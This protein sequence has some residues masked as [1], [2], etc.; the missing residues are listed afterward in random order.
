MMAL[1]DIARP[2][3]LKSGGQF[4]DLWEPFVD[5]ENKFSAYGPDLSGQTTKLRANDGVHFT[6]A[7]A[8]KAAHFVELELRRLMENKP[9]STVIA[10][11]A[12]TSPVE[13]LPLELQP[14]GV[15]RAI[16]RM[17]QGLPE[18]VGIPNLPMKPAAGPILTLNKPPV[19]PGATL[20][21]MRDPA[22]PSDAQIV[23]ERVYGEGRIG[24][25][26]PGRVDDFRWSR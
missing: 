23:I 20:A 18:P 14:G 21:G 17:V 9:A 25:S 6:K 12:E 24:D 4:V 10:I 11:P 5:A 1:N 13:K 2:Q 19:S 16:D 22:P 8:R 15:D 3:V 26:K 7:G